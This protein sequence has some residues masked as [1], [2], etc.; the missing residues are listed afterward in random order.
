MQYVIL[1]KERFNEFIANLK[2]HYKVMA[3]VD[4]GYNQYAFAEV[5][6]AEDIALG[7]LPTILPP[8]KYFM[9]Q[10]EKILEYAKGADGK[11]EAVVEY[12]DIVLFGVHTCD[13]A[14]IQCLNIA[15]SD[16]PKDDNLSL[17]HI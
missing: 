10:Y 6:S 8:K 1:K 17:I 3:P 16:T 15:F 14:G 5:D 9:P 11:V 4:K 13:L 2:H 12:E 7:Y